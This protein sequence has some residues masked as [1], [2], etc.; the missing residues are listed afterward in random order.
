MGKFHHKCIKPDH[1]F[2]SVRDLIIYRF[3]IYF[4]NNCQHAD[5]SV[6]FLLVI[7][8]NGCGRFFILFYLSLKY[9]RLMGKGKLVKY[10]LKFLLAKSTKQFSLKILIAM[11]CVC[12]AFIRFCLVISFNVCSQN[13]T[14]ELKKR[15]LTFPIILSMYLILRWVLLLSVALLRGDELLSGERKNVTFCD[16]ERIFL[17]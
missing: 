2:L 9:F 17:K 16:R 15:K 3:L 7:V 8:S 4:P 1:G 10:L 12:G 11:S 6:T 13:I 14:L 5:G